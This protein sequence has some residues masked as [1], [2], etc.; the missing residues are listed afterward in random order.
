MYFT[1]YTVYTHMFK[2]SSEGLKK[3]CVVC[4][5]LESLINISFQTSL[6]FQSL[7]TL[8]EL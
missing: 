8:T 5:L 3:A 6:C 1:W 7:D 2:V 4:I